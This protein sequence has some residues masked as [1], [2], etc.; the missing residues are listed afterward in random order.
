[1]WL[2][3]SLVILFKWFLLGHGFV[4]LPIAY[5]E[6]IT[7][8]WWHQ[9]FSIHLLIV[10]L[11]FFSFFQFGKL[12]TRPSITGTSK[13]CKISQH[14]MASKS[15]RSKQWYTTSKDYKIE[16]C[17]CECFL[18]VSFLFNFLVVNF[19]KHNNQ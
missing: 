3:F 5:S 8:L 11:S 13:R 19:A 10:S 6:V 18:H 7:I 15:C 16:Q 1:M 12:Q 2:A 9:T 4:C 17:Y 14:Y